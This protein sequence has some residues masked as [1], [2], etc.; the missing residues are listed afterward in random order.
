MASSEELVEGV[1]GW[2]AWWLTLQIPMSQSELQASHLLPLNLGQVTYHIIDQRCNY[3]SVID[4]RHFSIHLQ[5]KS[6]AIGLS[7]FKNSLVNNELI[8]QS[9]NFLSKNHRVYEHLTGSEWGKWAFMH[10][11]TLHCHPISPKYMADSL[12]GHRLPITNPSSTPHSPFP[13]TSLQPGMFFPRCHHKLLLSFPP[14]RLGSNVTYHRHHFF[15]FIF[16]YWRTITLQYYNG[17]CHTSTWIGHRYTYVPSLL[18][19]PPTSLP[20]PLQTLFLIGLYLNRIFPIAQTVKNLPAMQ[21]TWVWSLGQKDLEKGMAI[22]SSILAWRIP[23]TEEP[24]KP[25]SLGSQSRTR[26]SN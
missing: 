2:R 22:H 7:F 15:S 14:S 3:P 16:F 5:N 6:Q 18:N 1:T 13:L 23:W 10:F 8:F 19:S 20:I 9:L 17:F 11:R 24:G 21:K 4:Q 12:Q 25:Q 26:L